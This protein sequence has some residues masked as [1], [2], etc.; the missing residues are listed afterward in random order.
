MAMIIIMM[1]TQMTCK[2]LGKMKMQMGEML[3][4]WQIKPNPIVIPKSKMLR[5]VKHPLVMLMNIRERI[6]KDQEMVDDNDHLEEGYAKVEQTKC[7]RENHSKN[8][9]KFVK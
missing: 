2:T 5:K 6:A 1:M 7:N 3:M 9:N 4:G 8:G